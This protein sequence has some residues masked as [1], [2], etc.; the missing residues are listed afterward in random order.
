MEVDLC[1]HATLASG[2]VI[3][4]YVN[5]G[6]ASIVFSSRSGDL[7][8]ERKEN[9]LFMD[10]PSR[11]PAPCVP[12]AGLASLLGASPSPVFSSRDIMAVFEDENTVRNLAPDLARVAELAT[13]ALIVTAPGKEADFVSRFFAPGAGVPEDPVT[14]SSHCTLIPYWAERLGKTNLRALQLSK[15]GGELFCAHKKDRVSIGGAC[16][17]YLAGTITI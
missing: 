15:R 9:L 4:E 14:G 13:F 3:F 7:L 1:G 2:H 17:T 8:V 16:V 5:R 10:F 12:P 11:K 6:L